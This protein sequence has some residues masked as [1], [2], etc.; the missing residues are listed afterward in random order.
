VRGGEEKIRKERREKR[1]ME[2]ESKRGF[3]N[4]NSVL[5]LQRRHIV[6]VTVSYYVEYGAPCWQPWMYHAGI[7][8]AEH[9]LD[10]IYGVTSG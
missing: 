9:P 8:A 1:E 4:N 5:V 2:R 3:T 10:W 6:R 7:Q